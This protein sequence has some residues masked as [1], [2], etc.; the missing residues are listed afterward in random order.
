M[1]AMV[2]AFRAVYALTFTQPGS[3]RGPS[4]LELPNAFLGGIGQT[5]S[6]QG[7]HAEFVSSIDLA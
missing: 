1:P 3:S 7:R 2:S 4:A 5:V 6:M